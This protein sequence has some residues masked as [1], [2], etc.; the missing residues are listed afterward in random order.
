MAQNESEDPVNNV[1]YNLHMKNV[2]V[3]FCGF[4]DK[5]QAD[6]ILNLVRALGGSN[7]NQ[8]TANVTHLLAKTTCGCS[9]YKVSHSSDDSKF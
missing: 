9:R 7:R 4:N 1:K 2:I 3:C 6:H 8:V 5:K